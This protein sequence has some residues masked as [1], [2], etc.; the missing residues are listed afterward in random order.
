MLLEQIKR[1]CV[2]T[3]STDSVY[4]KSREEIGGEMKKKKIAWILA[5]LMLAMQIGC[6]SITEKTTPQTA[7]EAVTTETASETAA[8]E[9]TQ[10]AE[11][12]K[13]AKTEAVEIEIT[14]IQRSYYS[15]DNE[16]ELVQVQLQ[17]PKILAPAQA[18]T[19][20]INQIFEDNKV[21]AEAI[22]TGEQKSDG[23]ILGGIVPMAKEYQDNLPYYYAQMYE[24]TRAD[25]AVI[26]MSYMQASYA[27]GAHG[28]NTVCGVNYDMQT[29]EKITIADLSTDEEAFRQLCIDL[30]KKQASEMEKEEVVF[31]EGYEDNIENIITD[32]TFFFSEKGLV[33]ISQE[34]MLQPYSSGVV[35]FTIP[36]T[37]LEGLLKD[38]WIPAENTPKFIL[39]DVSII[40]D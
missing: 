21:R 23:D 38:N 31:F 16:T 18:V 36:Y 24:P 11:E 40:E 12:T 10:T 20:Q 7:P 5:G 19:D 35:N 37:E 28:S 32:D 4:T 27:G 15:D 33:L 25:S 2:C 26:S 1:V 9:E 29:G 22:I 3:A 8:V 30:V 6:Q 14:T 17:I 13:D 34:Y 39:T